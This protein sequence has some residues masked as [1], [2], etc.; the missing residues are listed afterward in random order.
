MEGNLLILANAMSTRRHSSSC[1]GS[2]AAITGPAA[3]PIM[4]WQSRAA[5]TW[6]MIQ[7]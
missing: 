2:S 4:D 7:L 3:Q 5:S 6:G 1:R